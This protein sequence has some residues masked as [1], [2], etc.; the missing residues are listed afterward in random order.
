MEINSGRAVAITTTTIHSPKGLQGYCANAKNYGHERVFFIIA[1]DK[2]T[3]EGV[4]AFCTALQREFGYE[5]QYL[6]VADQEKILRPFPS[7]AQHL[8]YNSLSRRNVALLQAYRQGA[9]V[10]VTIDDD[11]FSLA[12]Q[13]FVGAHSIVGQQVDYTEIQASSGWYNVCELL[14]EKRGLPFYHR[15]FPLSER[16]QESKVKVRKANGRVVVNAGLWLESPDLDAVTWL[17]LP[18][19]VVRYG[20]HYP[21]GIGLAPGTWSPFNSQNTALARE[22]LPAYFLWPFVGLFVDVWESYI[23]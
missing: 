3:P 17:D 5:V 15:G 14:V 4:P 6:D 8:P 2:K 9:D 21:Q 7:L 18:I 22:V 1:G 13:D 16:W 20:D 10:I 11:N 12:E 19:E 23:V